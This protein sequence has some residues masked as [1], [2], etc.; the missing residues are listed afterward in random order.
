LSQLAALTPAMRGFVALYHKRF[1]RRFPGKTP[2]LPF[3]SALRRLH[4][5]QSRYAGAELARLLD[6]FF[7]CSL[8]HIKAQNYSLEAFV[9]NVDVLEETEL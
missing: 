6:V 9:H 5:V 1:A 2:P 4:S 3:A 7:A 8:A